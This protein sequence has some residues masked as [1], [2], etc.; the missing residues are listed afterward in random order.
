V[1]KGKEQSSESITVA[2]NDESALNG[3]MIFWLPIE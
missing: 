3:G 1:S 2:V